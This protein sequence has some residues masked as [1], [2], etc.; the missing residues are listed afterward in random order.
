MRPGFP[1]K[2]NSEDK[3]LKSM[4]L[5][6][7]LAAVLAGAENTATRR[8]MGALFTPSWQGEGCGA[9][10]RVSSSG[11]RKAERFLV[12]SQENVSVGG[13]AR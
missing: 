13:E 12:E 11:R 4:H 8:R 1:V 5:M 2:F 3:T 9:A 10:S 7:A 6:T